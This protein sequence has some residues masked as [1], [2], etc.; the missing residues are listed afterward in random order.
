MPFSH[1]HPPLTYTR[2]TMWLHMDALQPYDRIM[3]E[4]FARSR[5]KGGVSPTHSC[6]G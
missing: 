1:P 2:L 5:M 3:K 6:G 4:E